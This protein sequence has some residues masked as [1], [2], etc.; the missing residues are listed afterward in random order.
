MTRVVRRALLVSVCV[1]AASRFI[2]SGL[3]PATRSL[4][5][6]FAAV[7]PTSYF[8]QFRPDF[9]TEQVWSGW[10]YGPMLH[11]LTLPLLLVPRWSMVPLAWALVNCVALAISFR[12]VRRLPSVQ[13]SPTATV[14]LAAM[15]L[16]YQPLA[17][18][19]AQGNIE[20]VEMALILGAIVALSRKKE[21]LSG[22]VIGAAAMT[23]FL[24]FGF[25]VWFLLKRSWRAVGC[26]VATVAV[27]AAVASVTL[28]WQDAISLEN[29]EWSMGTP[30]AGVQ[31]LSITSLFMHRTSVLLQDT[32]AAGSHP[33]PE[34]FPAARADLAFRVGLGVSFLLGAGLAVA[35][36]ARRRQPACRFEVAVLFM[37]MFMILPWNHDYY[38]IFALVPISILFLD[39]L[40]RRDRVLLVATLT[41]YL[42]ISPPV[43]FSWIDRL[44]WLQ[45]NFADVY[46]YLSLP[47][48]GALIVWVASA[49]RMLA[50]GAE[51]QDA[52]ASRR[53]A[54]PV[55]AVVAAVAVVAV[56]VII[57]VARTWP[58]SGASAA[59]SIADLAPALD[60]TGPPALAL[61]PDGEYLAY[62]ARQDHVRTLCIHALASTVTMCI[63]KTDDAAGPFFSPDSRWVAFFAGR[64][65]K[66][67]PVDGATVQLIAEL[68]GGRGGHWQNDGTILVATSASGILRV[69]V[70]RGRWNVLI[71]PLQGDGPYSW[72]A[73]LPDGGG[74][75]FVI[76]PPG[77]SFGSGSIV[78]FSSRT[79]RR[80]TVVAGSQPSFDQATGRLTYTSAGRILT[81][82][83][84]PEALTIIGPARPLVANVLAAPDAGPFVA[85]GGSQTIAFVP[86]SQVPV[87][88]RELVWVD[89]EGAV[90]PLPVT[91][92]T[93]Q[94]PRVSPD[95][96]KVV[97]GIRGAVTDLWTYDLATF[98]PTRITFTSVANESPVWTPD[99]E[100]AFS[101]PIRAGLLSEPRA[102]VLL[103]PPGGTEF[104]AS[105]LWE[106]RDVVSLGSWSIVDRRIVG[107]Q[108]GDLWMFDPTGTL[109]S[110]TVPREV[111]PVFSPDGRYFAYAS[112][113]SGRSEIYIKSSLGS[114]DRVRVTSTGGSEPVW[115]RDGRELFYR[116]GDALVS[117]PVVTRPEFRAGA[118][119]VLFHGAYVAGEGP[120]NYDVSGDGRRFLMLREVAGS[121]DKAEFPG[122]QLL[123]V[124]K[125]H[126]D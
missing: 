9:P 92:A 104:H 125:A 65:L 26:G 47:I 72:P 57:Y 18:C 50:T 115:S 55:V 114:P 31:E 1:F 106:G 49:Q 79:G 45:S 8:A 10:Y 80:R 19:L 22:I 101:V 77:G 48:L 87:V 44:G 71:P 102:A 119:R 86:G 112:N 85:Y 63:P 52:K 39:A 90:T 42:L 35:L 40:A 66:K 28:G 98:A 96:G 74:V 46:S 21:R 123:N 70:A 12:L 82:P 30:L 11:F 17:N 27:I 41:G 25:L 14:V 3:L 33:I 93:F 88:R 78:A 32:S 97:V 36:F 64:Q 69:S 53:F 23:K 13:A 4:A 76:A 75:L 60:L 122:V 94:T 58:R 126:W 84:D 43:P 61:S 51:D 67:V 117:V 110:Q 103:T 99:G 59:S 15:W 56:A 100:I 62:L 37:T 121:L 89:R 108:D 7:F 124:R 73:V 38:Y 24:P 54:G 20:I 16:L 105:R 2:W 111:G 68:D 91:P 34:W 109:L 113:D 120:A 83:F 81:V 6:D 29:M 116:N 118:P 5:G 107:S 95:G